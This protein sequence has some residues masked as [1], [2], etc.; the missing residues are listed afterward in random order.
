[1]SV[2]NIIRR[3]D[4]QND[5]SKLTTEEILLQILQELKKINVHLEVITDEQIQEK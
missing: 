3:I 2:G 5:Y 1:M 4:I